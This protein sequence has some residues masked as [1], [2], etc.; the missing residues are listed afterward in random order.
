MAGKQ[1]EGKKGPKRKKG[2]FGA[3]FGT[4]SQGL[5]AMEVVCRQICRNRR[6]WSLGVC[7]VS[8]RWLS[9]RPRPE[10]QYEGSSKLE[11]LAKLAR[12]DRPAGTLL[13]LWPGCYSIAL[14]AP[15]GDL[16]D[17]SLLGLFTVGAFIMRGAGCT[18]NDMWDK[19]FDKNVARTVTR[20][21]ASGRCAV[22]LRCAAAFPRG[23]R[24]PRAL[25]GLVRECLR[26]PL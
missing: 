8:A 24:W 10:V 11:G 3:A 12:L 22:V 6:P 19:D 18:V 14:A 1:D 23:N 26:M 5:G 17:F 21:L 2:A 13:L 4:L 7:R 15:M 16:P 20:P 25:R 9:H